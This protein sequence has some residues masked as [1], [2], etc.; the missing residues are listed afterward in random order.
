MASQYYHASQ[1]RMEQRVWEGLPKMRIS[2]VESWHS[3]P[4]NPRIVPYST[5]ITPDSGVQLRDTWHL[6]ITA[7]HLTAALI[8]CLHPLPKSQYKIVLFLNTP[9]AQPM[10]RPLC[11]SALKKIPIATP[12]VVAYNCPTSGATNV[13]ILNEALHFGD[14]LPF[15][16]QWYPC[17]WATPT[18]CTRFNS[19]VRTATDYVRITTDKMDIDGRS[20][21]STSF[22]QSGVSYGRWGMKNYTDEIQQH[23]PPP[24]EEKLQMHYARCMNKSMSVHISPLLLCHRLLRTVNYCY[25]E[26]LPYCHPLSYGYHHNAGTTPISLV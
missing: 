7:G 18:T 16:W 4:E 12:L 13:L 15:L 26:L 24:R 17:R 3:Y 25:S 1:S 21:W 8:K 11:I 5:L 10:L 6:K 20:N 9:G 14:S 19:S 22:G 23:A 2:G